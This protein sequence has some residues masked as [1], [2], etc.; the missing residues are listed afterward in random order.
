MPYRSAFVLCLLCATLSSAAQL[1]PVLTFDKSDKDDAA[2]HF[3]PRVADNAIKID[4]RL[5]DSAWNRALRITDFVNEVGKQPK[6][7]MSAAYDREYLYLGFLC[8]IDRR[9]QLQARAK[10]GAR[11]VDI[12]GD[13]C[14]DL[15]FATG[16]G[17]VQILINANGAWSDALKGDRSWNPDIEVAARRSAAVWY[18]E[19]K[20]KASSL[21]LPSEFEGRS[22]SIA[23]GR[24]DPQNN[25]QT[26][27]KPYGKTSSAPR[28]VFGNAAA[29]RKV[30][31]QLTFSSGMQLRLVMDREE[32]PRFCQRG[33]G[34]LRIE[35]GG[36]DRV[37]N[38]VHMAL[39][40]MDGRRQVARQVINRVEG[41]VVD[42]EMDLTRIPNGEYTLEASLLDGNKVFQRQTRRLVIRDEPQQVAGRI[43]LTVPAGP[44]DLPAYGYTFGVP[45]PWGALMS[46]DQVRLVDAGGNEIPMQA[47]ATSRWS[48]N[49]HVRWMLIDAVLPMREVAQSLVLE[50]G[51]KVSRAS[52]N[53]PVTIADND[54]QITVD[55]GAVQFT[56]PRTHSPGIETLR[57]N[58]EIITKHKE[59]G[60]YMIDQDGTIYRG[61]NDPHPQVVIE[62]A[63]PIK[64]QVSVTGWHVSDTGAKLGKFI[65]RYKAY[66]GLPLVQMDHTFI[67]TAD[68]KTQYHDIGHVLPT[69]IRTG[70]FGA[71][72]ITPF[73]LRG[74][75]DSAYLIQL[76]DFHG[77]I[78]THG[79]FAD[80]FSRAEGWINTGL[81]TATVRDFWQNF[82]KELEARPDRLI[83]HFWP[84]HGEARLRTGN[85]LSARN[86]Y[87]HWFAHEGKLLDF[88]VPDEFL[89]LIDSDDYRVHARKA[90]PAGLSKTHQVLLQAGSSS[91]EHDRARSTAMAFQSNPT[92]TCDPAWI[93]A[94]KVFGDIAPHDAEKYP[95]VEAAIDGTMQSIAR[96]NREDRDYGM[97]CYG[98][99]HHNWLWGD[100]RIRLYRTWRQTH[101]NWPRWPWLQYAR[102]G[103]KD[104]FDYACRNGRNVVDVAHAHQDVDESYPRGKLV[105]G[106]CDY[107]GF[108]KWSAGNRLGYNSVGD[109]LLHQYY[110]TGNRRALDTALAHGQ[111]LIDDNRALSSREGSAR[112]TS[113]V[114]HFLHTWDND[115][116]ELL[117]RHVDEY[118]AKQD[119]TGKIPDRPVLSF[120]T[121][122]FIRYTDLTRAQRGRQLTTRWA[123]L[124]LT[125]DSEKRLWRHQQMIDSPLSSILASLSQ[126]Y[127]Y[128]GEERY[129][130][131]AK[132]RA[133][134]FYD[135]IYTG[136]DPRYQNLTGLWMRNM[137]WSWFLTDLPH[138]VYAINQHRGDVKPMPLPHE[139]QI[140]SLQRQ[141]VD[142]AT[143]WTFHARIR[144]ETDR[145]FEIH[146]P[147]QP[148]G[149]IAELKPLNGPGKTIRVQGVRK[150]GER[151]EIVHI[152]VPADGVTEYAFRLRSMSSYA[153]VTLPI[154]RGQ[155]DLRE[156]YPLRVEGQAVA[157]AGGEWFWFDLPRGSEQL[158][159]QLISRNINEIQIRNAEGTVVTR[160]IWVAANGP[161]QLQ[162]PVAGSN[163]GWSLRFRGDG[164]KD[165]VSIHGGQVRPRNNNRPLYIST[166]PE[167]F[168]WPATDQVAW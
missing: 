96:Q 99:S 47:E 160:E 62:A 17:E 77:K 141:T 144:Q 33:I 29:L 117:E 103:D 31:D 91:W 43:D 86:A 114:S 106:I 105:G 50:Y 52:I 84:G 100:R 162:V 151:R 156:V 93:C 51:P 32:Y 70:F 13:H 1:L 15:K 167:K 140:A 37:K 66:R 9:T 57:T 137:P 40:V 146:L 14:L 101:H 39:A 65:V 18:V 81:L 95:E 30:T 28:F 112:I 166:S 132:T 136:D 21:W 12:W 41:R 92:V 60:P 109:A 115:A 164:V 142:D 158:S 36:G 120:W 4:G 78:Y 71:P 20:I 127:V 7:R 153:M 27:S 22:L 104:K 102:S 148:K 56:I 108:V 24:A 46:T 149:Y 94:S 157:I 152:D 38:R 68:E 129:L 61:I 76:D 98:D 128:T 58:S 131:M 111:Q 10:A 155:T 5:S 73:M 82:P 45:M 35:S 125:T 88:R 123:D 19:L 69:G 113:L 64:A 147:L 72:R 163:K 42:F 124:I 2:K 80:E 97:W 85:R 116:L 122:G 26:L 133:K 130:R 59:A 83:L 34:R 53:T 8:T 44:V 139:P 143:W 118:V 110:F 75:D 11:D 49:G 165:R 67:I 159:L 87:Q 154:A 126:A 3:M 145:P 119:E 150:E 74:K 48:R 134:Q 107:K 23:V 79:E 63:G 90:N 168:F 138:Y 55:T 135:V 25:L 6:T 16:A 89:A 121:T 161:R 54:A